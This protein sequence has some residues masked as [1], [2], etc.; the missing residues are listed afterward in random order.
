MPLEQCMREGADLIE[1]AA[2]RLR[3]ALK[4]GMRCRR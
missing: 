2:E 4:F 3:R 1:H